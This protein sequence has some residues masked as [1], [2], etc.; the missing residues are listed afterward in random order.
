LRGVRGEKDTGHG[1]FAV[2]KKK[3]KKDDWRTYPRDKRVPP[4]L[5]L[6]LEDEDD[7]HD[8]RDE[9]DTCAARTG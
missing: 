7:D 8:E 4:R 5:L 2:E 3:K 6:G 9:E 1:I